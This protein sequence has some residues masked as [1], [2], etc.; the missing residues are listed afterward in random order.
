M[1]CKS[2]F[3]LIANCDGINPQETMALLSARRG[4][5]I[6][7]IHSQLCDIKEGQV[8]AINGWH[9]RIVCATQGEWGGGS[10]ASL[11]EYVNGA[12]SPF[13]SVQ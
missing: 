10:A 13:W 2:V 8:S 3:L 6:F 7:D 9:Y 4:S 1:L 11:I 12:F 5:H